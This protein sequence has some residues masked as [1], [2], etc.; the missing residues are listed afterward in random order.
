MSEPESIPQP[1][2]APSMDSGQVEPTAEQ[3][4]TYGTAQIGI[5]YDLDD[6][7]LQSDLGPIPKT[8]LVDGVRRTLA[9]FRRLYEA[10]RL[11]TADLDG[12]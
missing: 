12:A 8:S 4:V 3:L 6:S 1:A 5:A 9:L 2:A 11:D 10:G 7:A